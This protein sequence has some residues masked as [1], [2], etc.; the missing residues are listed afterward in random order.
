[1]SVL[2]RLWRDQRVALIG[3]GVALL[4]VVFFGVR[5]IVAAIYW[6][7]PAHHRQMPE[8]WMTPGY[9]AHSWHLAPPEVGDLLGVTRQDGRQT[10]A[11]LARAR[12]VPVNQLITELAETLSGMQ[13]DR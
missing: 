4:L 3:F 7:D 5:M 8:P 9:I 1:M 10:L 11:E 12:G 13:A 6:A 2:A